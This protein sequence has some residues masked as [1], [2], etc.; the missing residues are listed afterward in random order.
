VNGGMLWEQHHAQE[1][2]IQW[3]IAI[4]LM[5]DYYGVRIDLAHKYRELHHC[6]EAIPLYLKGLEEEP[7]LPLARV[8]LIACYLELA[9]WR[10]AR[11]TSLVA[12]ADEFSGAKRALVYMKEVADSGLV[13]TDSGGGINQWKGRHSLKKP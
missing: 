4:R 10:N 1:A 7:D 9:Q 3:L 11:T 12:I 2:E 8:G 5:P 6:K 13:A